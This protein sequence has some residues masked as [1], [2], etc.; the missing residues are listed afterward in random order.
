MKYLITGC[1]LKNFR[2]SLEAE[3]IIEGMLYV[4]FLL[5]LG[6]TENIRSDYFI[7]RQL[8]GN[9]NSTFNNPGAQFTG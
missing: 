2:H 8:E 1:G 9:P 3:G 6:G 7:G 4:F 5:E